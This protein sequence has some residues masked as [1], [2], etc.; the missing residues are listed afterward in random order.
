MVRHDSYLLLWLHLG[1]ADQALHRHSANRHDNIRP[2][3]NGSI[4][5][6]VMI[7]KQSAICRR[8][9]IAFTRW[10]SS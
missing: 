7:H 3:Y 10:R 6:S 9:A 4:P 8:E 5:L 2:F 1:S